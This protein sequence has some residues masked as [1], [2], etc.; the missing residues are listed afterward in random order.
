MKIL[1]FGKLLVNIHFK[2]KNFIKKLFCKNLQKKRYIKK[3]L[4]NLFYHRTLL[5][6]LVILNKNTSYKVYTNVMK[7][8]LLTLI[9]FD[10]HKAWLCLCLC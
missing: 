6:N 9:E 7:I 1:K 5:I 8:V 3:Y 2:N 10:K 4:I